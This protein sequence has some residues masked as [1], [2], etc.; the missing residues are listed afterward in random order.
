VD[1]VVLGFHRQADRVVIFRLGFRKGILIIGHPY[2]IRKA[3]M[4]D[5]ETL[6]SFLKQF[7][8]DHSFIP[9]EILLPFPAEDQD[10]I[11]EWL[12]DQ[13]R[14]RVEMLV[15]ERGD[16]RSQ[17]EL[18]N[19]NAAQALESTAE[20]ERLSQDALEQL[21]NMLHLRKLPRWI[22]CYDISNFGEKLAAGSMVKFLDG[23]PDKSGY[24][25]FRIKGIQAQNDFEMMRQILFR[26]FNRALKENQPLPDLI[27]LDGG[28]GQLGMA[29]KVFSELGI[30][31]VEL[32]ALAK[33]REMGGALTAALVK[34]PE[35]VFL[36]GRKN[37]APVRQEPAKHLLV[38]VRDEAHR[39]AVSYLH[40]LREN[41]FSRS[42]L[43][44]IP[45]IGERKKKLLLRH[46]GSVKKIKRASLEE[47]KACPGISAS[48]AGQVFDFFKNDAFSKT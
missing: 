13:S 28:K 7:Y 42:V 9:R 26:R 21:K 30:K 14:Q 47:L 6:G 3:P 34:K 15:P 48:D 44:E 18:A 2:F 1:R 12:A 31:D 38:R 4:D 10:L 37:P 23:D 20:K 46:F 5:S 27:I 40:K 25:R 11:H 45:G 17:V 36:P 33:E 43:Q 39:F 41:V 16:K 19:T 29:L 24:R 8:P 32:A 22:E 35:R